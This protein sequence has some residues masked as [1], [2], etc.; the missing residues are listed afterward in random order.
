MR[1]PLNHRNVL[2][3][4]S[5]S[6]PARRAPSSAN[7]GPQVNAS[8]S[9]LLDA[10]PRRLHRPLD[11][12]ARWSTICSTRRDAHDGLLLERNLS[13][14]GAGHCRCQL[15]RRSHR[16]PDSVKNRVFIA[17][18][19]AYQPVVEAIVELRDYARRLNLQRSRRRNPTRFRYWRMVDG[20][21]SRPGGAVRVGARPFQL[22]VL[23]G[24]VSG[25]RLGL[26]EALEAKDPSMRS[27][28][29]R[30]AWSFQRKQRDALEA[31]CESTLAAIRVELRLN[32]STDTHAHNRLLPRWVVARWSK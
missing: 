13:D 8:E 29:K 18:S 14:R 3:L 17:R 27:D 12:F 5:G 26:L 20:H 7:V 31:L 1:A 22:R 15:P 11:R 32:A 6:T 23:P 21:P 9:D 28:E 30:T 19:E 2:A 10:K 25:F 24:H 4:E 16:H